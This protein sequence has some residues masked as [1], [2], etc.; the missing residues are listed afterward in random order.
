MPYLIPFII[1]LILSG[2]SRKEMRTVEPPREIFKNISYPNLTVHNG[3]YYFIGQGPDVKIFASENLDSISKAEP[4]MIF[5][6]GENGKHNIWSP[7]MARIRDK[8][9]IYF[10]GDDGNTD[11]HQLYVLENDSDNPLEGDWKLH[12]PII[13]NEEW[14]YGIHPSTFMVGDRQ[15]LVWSGWEH[16]RAETETQCIFIAEMENPWTLRSQRVLISKPDFE[17]ERQWIKPDG[18]RS[19]YPIFVNEN[20]E[21]F[22]SPDSSKVFVAYSASGIWTPYS[23]LGLLYADSGSNLLDTLSWTKL[24]EP[25]SPVYGQD[26]LMV[27]IS[28]ISVLEIPE[29]KGTY[30]VYQ[31]HEVTKTDKIPTIYISEIEWDSES[32]PVISFSR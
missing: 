1:L 18:T 28:N 24:P 7:E 5:N 30:V 8:W 27:G 32:L 13:T 4:K 12:G 21:G 31:A 11:N 29:K 3:M 20:P 23:S 25:L 2:C 26:S 15:Y 19:A 14:N 6:G 16:R 17:W 10:E 9:Y 22:V